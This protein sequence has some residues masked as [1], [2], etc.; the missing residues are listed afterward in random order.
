MPSKSH[1]GKPAE[2]RGAN[3]GVRTDRRAD[4]LKS[5]SADPGQSSYG[6]FRNEDPGAQHQAT[7]ASPGKRPKKGHGA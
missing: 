6:G 7:S 5:R 1:T 2:K 4:Q 3:P